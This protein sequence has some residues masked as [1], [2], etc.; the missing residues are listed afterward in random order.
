MVRRVAPFGLPAILLAF[1]VGSLAAGWDVGW[2][3]AIGVTIVV[4]NFVV[5]GLSLARAARISLTALA[6]VAMGGFV[7]RLGVIMAIMF[8]LNR[9]SWFSPLAFGLTV[10]PATILLLGFEMKLMAGGLGRELILPAGEKEQVA[11]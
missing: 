3:A 6:A 5:N 11:R 9:F 2:S 7:V 4:V 1:I 8:L 10:V